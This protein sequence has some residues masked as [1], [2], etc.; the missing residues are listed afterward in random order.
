M[1]NKIMVNDFSI[2]NS[3]GEI[4]KVYEP[5]HESD[6]QKSEF[7]EIIIED[8]E[9]FRFDDSI[10]CNDNKTPLELIGYATIVFL[11]NNK[12]YIGEYDRNYC[13]NSDNIEFYSI[14]GREEPGFLP[15][16]I[17]NNAY[18]FCRSLER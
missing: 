13:K 11:Y 3:I 2:K 10:N 15:E 18:K 5:V 14:N 17:V 16:D 9:F 8:G 12:I 1:S 7:K 4:Y 6:F